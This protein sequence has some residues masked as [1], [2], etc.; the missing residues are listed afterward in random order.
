MIMMPFFLKKNR[1]L[2][3]KDLRDNIES[4]FNKTKGEFKDLYFIFSIVCL[5]R[6]ARELFERHNVDALIKFEYYI[7]KIPE[8]KTLAEAMYILR[9][10][11]LLIQKRLI[12]TTTL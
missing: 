4:S 3:E 9:I 5:R 1:E 10:V 11:S 6:T 12:L 8:S 7:R 2:I